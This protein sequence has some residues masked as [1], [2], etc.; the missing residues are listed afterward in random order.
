MCFNDV[1]HSTVKHLSVF[2]LVI[3]ESMI[4]LTFL[5]YLELQCNDWA[6]GIPARQTKIRI[7]LQLLMM[8]AAKNS[9][10][11]YPRLINFDVFNSL[12][13]LVNLDTHRIKHTLQGDPT[14]Y[15]PSHEN[16]RHQ[17]MSVN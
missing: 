13:F 3:E 15:P 2:V 9:N 6:F 11:Y 10:K 5:I 14:S 12:V 7:Y 1:S 17:N 8:E 16:T 4:I